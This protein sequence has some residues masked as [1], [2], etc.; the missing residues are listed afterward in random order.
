M[1]GA[2]KKRP[3]GVGILLYLISVVLTL[4]FGTMGIFYGLFKAFYNRHFIDGLRDVD[5]KF[6]DMAIMKDQT[7]N[8]LCYE[9]FNKELINNKAIAKF[10]HTGETI[11]SVLGKNQLNNSLTKTGW[12]LANRLN[13]IEEN[14][15]INSIN[16]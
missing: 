11:S 1:T 5:S 10:G 9:W 8:V 15:C 2:N 14:H 3:L 12:W 13:K 6:Y 16:K 4:I 7:G